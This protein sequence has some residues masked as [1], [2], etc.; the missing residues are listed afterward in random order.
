VRC[1]SPESKGTQRARQHILATVVINLFFV[2]SIGF[3]ATLLGKRF[4]YYT[5]ATIAALLVFG[6]LTSL[7][8][9]RLAANRPTPGLGI[10]ERINVYAS[11]LWVA[12]LAI[13][14]WRV[15]VSSARRRLGK[16]TAT[17]QR[18][19]RVLQ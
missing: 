14:L 10:L 6:V 19:Q 18:M 1:P 17:L 5:C 16:L 3:G 13:A 9:P 2:L 12:V 8:I 11:M 15:E 4:R 7:Q